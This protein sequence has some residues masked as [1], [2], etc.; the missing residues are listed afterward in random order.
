[1]PAYGIDTGAAVLHLSASIGSTSIDRLTA[2]AEQALA[3]AFASMQIARHAEP[4]ALS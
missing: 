2:G 3:E 4:S 1:M